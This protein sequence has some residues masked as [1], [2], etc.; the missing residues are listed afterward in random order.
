MPKQRPLLGKDSD[1]IFVGGLP[2]DCSDDDLRDYFG[3]YGAV[4]DVVV[5]RDQETGH[6]R[7]FGF[8]V[9]DGPQ[10][11][12][13][14]MLDY[15]DHK[16]AGKWVEVKRAQAPGTADRKGGGKGDRDGGRNGG[17][18]DRDRD[19]DQDG[20]SGYGPPPSAGG[21]PGYPPPGYGY[22]PPGY[23]GYPPPGY[24]YPPPGYGYPPPGYGYPPPGYGYGPPPGYGQPP[25][26]YGSPPPP[27]SSSGYSPY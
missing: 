18:R 2:K 25:P 1:K 5:K 12:D 15:D 9:F 22:P 23:P 21:Y 14:V 7:G 6:S 4:K 8:V 10:P 19:R 11:V 17:G 20:S 3:K 26:G 16:I 24:G 13:Q 27:G